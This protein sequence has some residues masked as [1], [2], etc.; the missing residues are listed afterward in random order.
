MAAPL[1]SAGPGSRRLA[2]TGGGAHGAP[3]GHVR[4]AEAA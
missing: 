4:G 2:T 1:A 3:Y